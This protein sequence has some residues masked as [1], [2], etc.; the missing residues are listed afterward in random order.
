MGTAKR[1]HLHV[2]AAEFSLHGYF[3]FFR[4]EKYK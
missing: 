1:N 4:L 2:T 3:R